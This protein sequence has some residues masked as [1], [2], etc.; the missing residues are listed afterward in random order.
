MAA[1]PVIIEIRQDPASKLALPD[2]M[3]MK[4]R[5]LVNSFRVLQTVWYVM[6]FAS[7]AILLIY[8]KTDNVPRLV[9][10]PIQLLLMANA[11]V[12]ALKATKH[13]FNPQIILAYFAM[14]V[15]SHAQALPK[16]IASPATPAVSY[17]IARVF[18]AILHAKRASWMQITAPPVQMVPIYSDQPVFRNVQALPLRATGPVQRRPQTQTRT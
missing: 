5:E 8:W 12:A 1:F 13:W 4:Q 11:S 15:A 9:Q 16:I 14:R 17:K 7:Y 6:V 2:I 10:V 18:L 3:E